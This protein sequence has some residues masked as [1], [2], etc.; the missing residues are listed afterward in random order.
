MAFALL[1]GA[2]PEETQTFDWFINE[3]KKAFLALDSTLDIR[4][5]PN[6]GDYSEID[7]ALVWRHPKGV[8]NQFPNLKLIVSLAAGVDHVLS[9]KDLPKHIPLVRLT[10]PYMANDIVQYVLWAVLNH[11]KRMDDWAE[12]QK[13]KKWTRNPPIAYS[14]KKIGIM[15]LGFLGKRAA[16]TLAQIGLTV[17]GWSNSPK[18]IDHVTCFVGK[19][20]F[21]DFL[22][23][24]DILIC[25]LPL[26]SHTDSLLCEKTFSKL[27]KGAYLINVG[28]GEQLVESDLVKALDSGQLSGACLDVL[29]QEPL[30]SDHVFWSYSNIRITPHIASVT[31]PETAAPQLFAEYRRLI[32]GAELI[33]KVDYVKGY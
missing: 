17:L 6:L 33:N 29:R 1:V 12:N 23:Q 14:H 26:T 25:M 9:D 8:L 28:R 16:E 27:P 21:S 10:D 3:F 7:V 19:D 4:A 2:T 15:G 31:H 18:K 11:V 32:Q 30:P 22:S 20:Q 13:N 5:W 24:T